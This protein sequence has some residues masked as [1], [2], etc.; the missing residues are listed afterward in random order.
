MWTSVREMPRFRPPPP[1][2][3]A[4]NVEPTEWLDPLLGPMGSFPPLVG[5]F[6]PSGYQ[7]YARVLHPARRFVGGEAEES[8]PLRW[9]EIASVRGKTMHPEVHLQGLIDT[10]DPFDYEHWG[11]IS[12]GGSEW[13]PPQEWLEQTEALVLAELLRAY[14]NTN[15]AWF[16]LWDGYGDLG[17]QEKDL[18]RGTV[19]RVSEPGDPAELVGDT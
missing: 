18:P 3:V 11:T 9:S 6:V 12:T 10:A 16:M 15:E 8:V 1:F 2:R 5:A 19:H 14:T 7:A 13:N 4:R 17:D